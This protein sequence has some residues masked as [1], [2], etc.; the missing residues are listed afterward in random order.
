VVWESMCH[1]E[2]LA[3]EGAARTYLRGTKV[4]STTKSDSYK[5][6][7]SAHN[8]YSLVYRSFYVTVVNSSCELLGTIPSLL[9]SLMCLWIGSPLN[10]CG[11]LHMKK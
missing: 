4:A 2:V 3:E 6:S 8:F 11:C 10:K 1:E 5:P 7:M 9:L